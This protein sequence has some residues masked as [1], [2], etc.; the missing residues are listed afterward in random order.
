MNAEHSYSSVD[1]VVVRL[2]QMDIQNKY[3]K[4]FTVDLGRLLQRQVANTETCIVKMSQPHLHRQSGPLFRLGDQILEYL[5]LKAF[6]VLRRSRPKKNLKTSSRHDE[7]KRDV[8]PS[9]DEWQ[10]PTKVYHSKKNQSANVFGY[11]IEADKEQPEEMQISID[12]SVQSCWCERIRDD[13]RVKLDDVGDAL[14]H[15]LDEVLCGSTNFKQLV[16][17]VPSV[18][19]NRTIGI[20]IFPSTT[21]W[22]VLQSRWNTFVFENFRRFD[23]HL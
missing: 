16:P 6:G 20:V 9:D 4:Q 15:A 18:H 12:G 23:S 13:S 3:A 10:Q 1:R 2:K 17:T 22:V 21:Y 8:E 5:K 14:L 11:I 19:V 7:D